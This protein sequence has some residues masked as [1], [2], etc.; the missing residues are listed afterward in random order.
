MDLTTTQPTLDTI[1]AKIS[2]EMGISRRAEGGYGPD[3]DFAT[4]GPSMTRDGAQ[5]LIEVTR[6]LGSYS[7]ARGSIDIRLPIETQGN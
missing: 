7:N 4:Y 2:I 6:Q 5:R 1:G 3:L